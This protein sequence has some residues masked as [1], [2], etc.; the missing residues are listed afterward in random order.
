MQDPTRIPRLAQAL[1]RAW[2][3]QPDLT[4]GQ[5]VG[6]LQHRGLSWGSTDE[7]ALE[8]LTAL[9]SEHPSLLDDPTTPALI[10]TTAPDQLVTLSAGAAVVRSAQYRDRMP[11][12]WEYRALRRTGPGLPLVLESAD[13]VEHRLGVV[14]LV[15][16]LPLNPPSLTG[17]KRQDV[18][19][20]RW[21]V[22]FVDGRRAV[23]GQ[24]IRVWEQGRRSVGERL[25]AFDTILE[26]EAGANMR[27]AP[28][29][30][31]E[32][33]VVGPVERVVLLEV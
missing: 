7:E 6:V 18:G 33:T 32:P 19:S 8:L 15:T 12:V 31:G 21:L 22:L 28:P 27:V 26:C 17:L 16:P 23:V 14:T 9:E 11:A 20:A 24:R 30:G 2:E 29:G 13:G 10:T 5:L 25:I 1:Q 3:G 4:L